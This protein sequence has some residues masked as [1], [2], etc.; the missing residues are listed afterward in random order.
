MLFAVCK[1]YKRFKCPPTLVIYGKILII[2][3]S[4]QPTIAPF[5][6]DMG[7]FSIDRYRFY[8]LFGYSYTTRANRHNR[9]NDNKSKLDMQQV[10]NSAEDY[11]KTEIALI[12]IEKL[13]SIPS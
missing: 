6:A 8:R 12:N 2:I 5:G 3:A 1:I 7:H 9:N 11:C 10:R 13:L 4:V